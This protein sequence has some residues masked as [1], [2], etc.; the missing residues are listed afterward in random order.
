MQIDL[1]SIS[2]LTKYKILSNAICPRPIAWISTVNQD[3]VINLAPFSFF[4]PMSS[5]PIVFSVCFGLKSNGDFKD[6]FK[7][8]IKEKRATIC[9]CDLKNIKAMHL[10]SEELDHQQSEA[11]HFDIV[12]QSIHAHY[13]PIPK[14]TQVAFLCDFY[15]LLEIGNNTKTLLLEAKEFFIQDD[16]HNTEFDF[17]LQNVGRVGREY[18]IG[19]KYISPKDLLKA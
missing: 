15:D 3:G 2:A 7:N 4:A 18:E 16:L 10:S 6:T 5:D 11:S 17:R 14:H 19:Q 8:I 12:M 13:P 1:S 9:M